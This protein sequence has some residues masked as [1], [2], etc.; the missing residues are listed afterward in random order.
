MI[1]YYHILGISKKAS[2][3]E[4]KEAYRKLALR[5]HPDKNPGNAYAEERFKEISHAYQVLRDSEKKAQHDFALVYESL[6]EQTSAYSSASNPYTNSYGQGPAGPSPNQ[7]RGTRARRPVF[8]TAPINDRQ[9]LVATAWAFGIF[10]VLAVMAIAF[11]SYRS[12][13]QEKLRIEQSELAINLFQ[14]AEQAYQQQNY[15]YSLHLLKTIGSEHQ[16][17]YDANRLKQE[18]LQRLE[19]HANHYFEQQEYEKAAEFFQLIVQN[20]ERY[21]ALVYAKLVSS[22]E[23]MADYPH[24]IEAYKQVISAEPLTIEARNRLA[25]LYLKQQDY[26]QA[27]K[28]YLQASEIVENEYQNFYGKAYA[29]MVN[30]GKTPDS[31]YQ[32]HCG[33]GETYSHLGRYKEADSSFKWAIFLR[34]DSPEAYYLKGLNMH[35]ALQT[36][37]ACKAWEEA[38]KKGS[39]EAA[40]KLKAFCK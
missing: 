29:L 11:S 6:N 15:G 38:R 20:Q 35:K 21:D 34:P 31:H 13:R 40:E 23:M 4:I 26:E 19:E 25:S 8:R 36:R 17:P 14:R 32:L 18:T 22:Y 10:F 7:T 39:K 37:E 3:K 30:P 33:L 24:A 9:N 16:I 5:Y 27:L 28:Y 1:N 12:Y 2:Q